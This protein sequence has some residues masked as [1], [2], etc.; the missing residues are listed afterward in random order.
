MSEKA[1]TQKYVD[2][3][4]DHE[5]DGI[6]EFDNPLPAWW[7]WTF[8]LTTIFAIFY[9]FGYH[10]LPAAGTF[11]VHAQEMAAHEA[12]MAA[13]SISDEELAAAVTDEAAIAV[14][15]D[16]FVTSCKSCHGDKGEGGIGPNLTDA[17]W[18]NGHEDRD[19]WSTIASGV[20]EKGMP[21]WRPV[22]G[23]SKVRE[24]FAY[25]SSLKGKNEE[26]K[27]PQGVDAAGNAP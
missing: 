22:L 18:L 23:D 3:P 15:R 26:G 7:L 8:A 27:A 14:G 4:T 20:L 16:L 12:A 13:N 21:A 17:Y 25:V 1:S 24:L 9:W 6:R 10:Q 19:I 11:E 2:I 5:Y